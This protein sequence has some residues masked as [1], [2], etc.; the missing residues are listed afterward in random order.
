VEESVEDPRGQQVRQTAR[1]LPPAVTPLPSIPATIEPT[2][3]SDYPVPNQTARSFDQAQPLAQAGTLLTPQVQAQPRGGNRAAGGDT[4]LST[5][6]YQIQ[7]L[8]QEL[9][10]LRG[11]MEDQDYLVK[12]LQ[13]D[14]KQ[15]YLDLD[16]RVVA[17]TQN[18]PLSG[19]VSQSSTA[20]VPRPVAP[21]AGGELSE[22]DAYKVAFEAMRVRDFDGSMVGF[23][24]LIEDYPNGQFTPNAFYWIGE[25]YLVAK[26]DAEMARQSFM[27]VVNLYPDHQKTPDALYKLGVVYHNLGDLDSARTYLNR[28]RNDYPNSSAAGLAAKYAA[29]L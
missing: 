27:Q 18:K 25:I 5:L 9:Q 26:S 1:D 3:H 6:F 12:R 2:Q 28:V 10:D 29:E 15:Q 24:R 22:R 13:Q 20:S 11:Q 8:Q 17:L 7:V 21:R 4:Q 23:Q 16:R 19:A 14:Q